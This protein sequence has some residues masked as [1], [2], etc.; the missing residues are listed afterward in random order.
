MDVLC[1]DPNPHELLVHRIA[2][3]TG[4][5]SDAGLEVIVRDPGETASPPAISLALGGSLMRRLR[6]ETDWV[7]I[8]VNVDQP[9]FWIYARSGL[10]DLRGCHLAGW[11]TASPP[12]VFLDAYLRSV[13]LHAA[14]DLEI[15]P[16]MPRAGADEERLER[17]LSGDADAGLF[18]SQL[19]PSVLK[20]EGLDELLFM[21]DVIEIPTTGIA[22]D[23]GRVDVESAEIRALV[24]VQ[25][26]ALGRLHADPET[27]VTALEQL[28]ERGTQA[29]AE[30]FYRT[31]VT[32]SFTRSGQTSPSIYRS[33]IRT[34]ADIMGIAEHPP[35]QDVY[36]T[37]G[38]AES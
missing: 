15:S 35:W 33:A 31:I 17:V 29:D 3:M 22:I 13:G 26:T 23:R 8:S 34:V 20:Q 12:A 2:T 25:R 37:G 28:F 14:H 27:A 9:L 16:V 30:D 18:G 32:R 36:Q 19:P 6:G 7:I 5:Y 4:A 10:T 21:G 11:P 24:E 38:T 1:M